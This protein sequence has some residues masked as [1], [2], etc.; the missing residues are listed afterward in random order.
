M[1]DLYGLCE[2]QYPYF[3][4]IQADFLFF[5]IFFKIERIFRFSKKSSFFRL[6]LLT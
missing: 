6:R 5:F 2:L 4:R 1:K 3:F